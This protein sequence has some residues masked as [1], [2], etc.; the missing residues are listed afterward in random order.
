MAEQLWGTYSVADHCTTYP[1]VADL[2]LYDR[3]LVPVPPN[4]DEDEWKRWRARKWEPDVQHSLLEELDDY[5]RRVPWTAELRAR[6]DAMGDAGNGAD[7]ETTDSGARAA[8]DIEMT[9]EGE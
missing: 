6:W 3:V 2:V 1:F 7:P 4:D 5:V 8:A 9:A